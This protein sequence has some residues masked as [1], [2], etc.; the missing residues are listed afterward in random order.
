MD[1]HREIRRKFGIRHKSDNIPHS[2]QRRNREHLAELFGELG[3]KEGAE[4]GVRWGKYSR[5]LCEKNPG[6]H[7][8]SIDPWLAYTYLDQAK[9]D[10]IYAGCVKNLSGLNVTILKKKSMDALADIADR[11]LD[12]V[13]ID[14]AH[15]FDN[16]VMDIIHWSKKV[17]QGG[18]IAVHDYYH[19]HWAGVVQAVDSYTHCHNIQPWYV[20][21]EVEST[22]FWV[23]P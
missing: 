1:I 5:I 11:S 18:I 3:Y 20:T 23:N 19:F 21:R 17:K 6:L 12:F 13:Y 9:Q 2:A 10:E 8:Y 15:D 16:A 7:L 14:G 22:A 4:I